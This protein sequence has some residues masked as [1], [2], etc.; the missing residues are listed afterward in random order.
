M[1]LS[2]YFLRHGETA[3]SRGDTFCGRL[4]PPL[5]D[6]GRNMAEEFAEAYKS[7]PLAAVFSSPQQRAVLTAEPICNN[8]RIRMQLN[9]G[10]REIAYGKWEGKT[11]DEV[12][13][14]FHDDYIL[15]LADPG[16]NAPTQGEKGVEI[17]RRSSQVLELIEQN[18]TSGNVLVVSHKAM[19]RIMLC[20]LLG[21]D[22]GR[23]RDRFQL[24]VGSICIIDM[25][26]HGPSLR[27]MNDRSYMS[28]KLRERPGT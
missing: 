22:L 9:D 24:P 20:S 11:R 3:S 15:W 28:A 6:A 13:K 5:T 26:A 14:E 21:I 23:F 16:W 7:L 27:L 17:A 25:T 8:H 19:I 1:A 18:Y 2:I 12:E 10:L 4:D